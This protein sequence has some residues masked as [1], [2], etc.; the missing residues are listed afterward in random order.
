MFCTHTY[1]HTGPLSRGGGGGTHR[2]CSKKEAPSK[3]DAHFS[4]FELQK[5]SRTE[6]E[7]CMYVHGMH[8]YDF[9]TISDRLISSSRFIPS[10]D[11]LFSHGGPRCPHQKHRVADLLSRFFYPS[12]VI[13]YKLPLY[14][15]VKIKIE[16]RCFPPVL[17][18]LA[19]LVLAITV[20][21]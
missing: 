12:Y 17:Q 10:N 21:D 9:S 4:F 5:C 8:T 13:W 18:G 1:T 14:N 7:S 19:R 6:Y 11:F 3:P 15:V 2:S 20:V 16:C